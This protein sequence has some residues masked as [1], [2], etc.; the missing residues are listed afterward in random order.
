MA[1]FEDV[2]FAEYYLGYSRPRGVG[3]VARLFFE[4]VFS[5]AAIAEVWRKKDILIWD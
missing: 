4:L 5:F 3:L 1:S 2:Q